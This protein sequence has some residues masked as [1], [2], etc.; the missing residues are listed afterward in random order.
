MTYLSGSG[1]CSYGCGS[2]HSS[3][4]YS[5]IDSIIGSYS[6]NMS[7]LEVS[8]DYDPNTPQIMDTGKSEVYKKE[9]QEAK[10]YDVP[11][12]KGYSAEAS[13]DYFSPNMFLKSERPQ[14]QFI[15]EVED[16]KD[17]VQE[18]F[19]A[20][21]GK[22]LPEDLSIVVVNQ[23]ELKQRHAMCNGK[24]SPGIQGFSI[25]KKGFGQSLIVVKEND[26]DLLM[27]VIGHEIGHVFNFQLNNQL[28]EEAKAFAFEMAWVKA[29]YEK[30]IA[31]LRNSIDQDP[32]PAKNGLHD[33]AFGFVKK[34]LM[35]GKDAFDIFNDLIQRRI[36][37]EAEN[38]T[39][40]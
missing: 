25:N 27:M 17:Y 11:Y 24:W 6:G 35:L 28:N 22:E 4:S 38:G 18:A 10:G 33:V 31:G 2:S 40:I 19:K 5:S 3:G 20:T 1:G 39:A 7:T 12:N 21:T 16:I 26:L 13:K 29:I 8:L 30:N 23:D 32:K 14:S 15:G 9:V 34:L 37:V 36:S